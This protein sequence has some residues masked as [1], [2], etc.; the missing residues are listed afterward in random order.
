MSREEDR[1]QMMCVRWFKLAHNEKIITSF[2]AGYV[3]S[4]DEIKRSRTGKRMKDM[5]YMNGTPDLLIPHA[6][7]FYHG[8]FIEMKTEKGVLN[9]N[10][11]E[12]MQELQNNS[13]K[14]EV[15]RSLEDFMKTVNTYFDEE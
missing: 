12:A 9:A 11:K 7:R 15:C 2:P 5:G 8:L 3:F 14:C 13:Y 4:G 10:Q 1:I 6:N